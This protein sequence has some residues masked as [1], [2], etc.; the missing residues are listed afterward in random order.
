M[1]IDIKPLNP[2]FGVLL[3]EYLCYNCYSMLV[4][5]IISEVYSN[6]KLL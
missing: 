1:I 2:I 4:G 5:G 6:K 3:W